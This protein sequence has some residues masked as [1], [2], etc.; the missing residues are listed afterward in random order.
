MSVRPLLVVAGIGNGSGTGAATARLFAKQGYRVALV[1]RGADSLNRLAGEITNE[2]GEAAG[3]P[4]PSYSYGD[5]QAVF[6]TIAAHKWSTPD[7]S[8][9]RV[10]LWN[11]GAGVF[12]TFLEVTE[13]DVAT[14]LQDNVGAAFAFSRR[15]ILAFKDNELDERGA[16]GTLLFTGATASI[17]GN[18]YTSAFAAGKHG[19][20]ALS[21]SLAKEFG[22]ENIHV[23]SPLFCQPRILTDRSLSRRSGDAAEAFKN[24]RDTRLDAESIAQSYLYLVRQD[25]SAWTWELDLRPAHEKW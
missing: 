14:S 7:R 8:E 21:Q 9:L 20:R 4:V 19:L 1:A 5:T 10:A 25:R 23:S 22:K 3:F 17:R 16:R 6:D 24:N 13:E 2:G 18:V 15:A 11:A 12:K